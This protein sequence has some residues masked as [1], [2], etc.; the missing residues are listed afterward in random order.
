[1]GD[2][3]DVGLETCDEGWEAVDG[4]DGLL[5]GEEG[6]ADDGGGVLVVGGSDVFGDGI[7]LG[8]FEDG[9]GLGLVAMFVQSRGVGRVGG[10]GSSL[11]SAVWEVVDFFRRR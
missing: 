6:I 10:G 4:E 1:M 5:S 3:G 11:S 7:V 2:V 8:E 9:A